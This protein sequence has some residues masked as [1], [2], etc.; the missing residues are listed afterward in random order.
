MIKNQ[1]W[2][3]RNGQG[4]RNYEFDCGGTKKHVAKGSPII[5]WF[6]RNTSRHMCTEHLVAKG[7]PN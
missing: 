7:W 4:P 3:Y 5:L 6:L 1:V 2:L